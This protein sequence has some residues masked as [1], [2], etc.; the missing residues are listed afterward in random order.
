MQVQIME[1]MEDNMQKMKKE[2]MNAGE[3]N[4]KKMKQ[5]D[6]IVQKQDMALNKRLAKRKKK[7]RKKSVDIKDKEFIQI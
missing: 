7:L 6:R 4:N 3:A 1:E 2:F 5:I